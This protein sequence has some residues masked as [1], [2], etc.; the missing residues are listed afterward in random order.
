MS[1]QSRKLSAAADRSPEKLLEIER[2]ARKRDQ[3]ILQAH[4]EHSTLDVLLVLDCTGSMR[5]WIHESKQ[6][7][8]QSLERLRNRG[9][10]SKVR[11]AF[12]GYRDFSEED[13]TD[14][15]RGHFCVNDFTDKLEDIS[16]A[17]AQQV[18]YGGGDGPE[19]VLGA[20]EKA[21]NLNWQHKVRVIMHVTD[22]PSHGVAYHSEEARDDYP[23]MGLVERGEAILR[24]LKR[25][26]IRYYLGQINEAET[27]QMYTKFLEHVGG[28][29]EWVGKFKLGDDVRRFATFL[30]STV[31]M[32]S[33]SYPLMA[34]SA[35]SKM[36]IPS[37]SDIKEEP[38]GE[39][40]AA[41][42]PPRPTHSI[43]MEGPGMRV[44]ISL[45]MP[46]PGLSAAG[47]PRPRT[48][49]PPASTAAV[50][51]ETYSSSP[52][53][54]SY[55]DTLHQAAVD[56]DS[57][58]DAFVKHHPPPSSPADRSLVEKTMTQLVCVEQYDCKAHEPKD[59][60]NYL[61]EKLLCL[62][63]NE[64]VTYIQSRATVR[65]DTQPFAKGACRL[66]HYGYVDKSRSVSVLK[67]D[68]KHLSGTR[69][70]CQ[71]IAQRTLEIHSLCSIMT[72]LFNSKARTLGI[73]ESQCPPLSFTE[74]SVLLDEN[75][76]YCMEPFLPGDFT[77]YN[78][79]DGAVADPEQ[80]EACDINIFNAAQAFSHYSYFVSKGVCMIVDLQGVRNTLTDPAM[81]S[82]FGSDPP[83]PTDCMSLGMNH[84]F[85]NHDCNDICSRMKLPPHPAQDRQTDS[86]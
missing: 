67:T 1:S 59:V 57:E 12:I 2:K 13:E 35:P 72:F 84:F 38:E 15:A 30:R 4:T 21:A 25:L 49:P 78:N 41:I 80:D 5:S 75:K 34:T 82:M 68:M 86:F 27:N 20:L 8:Q 45:G 79:N 55:S 28:D 54:P 56:A 74:V 16:K 40:S 19:D 73:S 10:Y 64:P 51:M 47:G 50:E 42:S 11:G 70:H 37:V 60:Y 77:K 71:R 61:Q 53:P 14:P 69:A 17:I 22:A 33:R 83:I 18:A 65:W 76:V 85:V 29:K 58:G 52:P 62:K 36:G 43:S 48:Q 23:E 32:A 63:N 66:A 3:Q 26:G 81:H 24:K 9:L 39:P 7:L 31:S 44:S 6:K 46:L